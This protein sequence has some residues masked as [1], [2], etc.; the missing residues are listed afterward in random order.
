MECFMAAAVKHFCILKVFDLYLPSHHYHMQLLIVVAFFELQQTGVAHL[1]FP[2][3]NRF[4]LY[5]F[6]SSRKN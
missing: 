2:P 4:T 6:I 5:G 1:P 3:D